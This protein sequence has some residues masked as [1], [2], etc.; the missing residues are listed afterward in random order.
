[1]I[2]DWANALGSALC[3]LAMLIP[4]LG[5]LLLIIGISRKYGARTWGP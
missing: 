5:A 4:P 3:E 2:R 1:M